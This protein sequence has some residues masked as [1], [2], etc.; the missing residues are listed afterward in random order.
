MRCPIFRVL[1]SITYLLITCTVCFVVVVVVVLIL[2]YPGNWRSPGENFLY[3]ISIEEDYLFI[4]L[5]IATLVMSKK[6]YQ[7]LGYTYEKD[8]GMKERQLQRNDTWDFKS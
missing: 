6:M 2:Q 8:T 4:Y 7:P 5:A 3:S 1:Y